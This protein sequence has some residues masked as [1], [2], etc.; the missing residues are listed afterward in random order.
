MF[1]GDLFFGEFSWHLKRTL[2]EFHL[3]IDTH[4][5]DSEVLQ[6]PDRLFPD[7]VGHQGRPTFGQDLNQRRS[8]RDR[9][10]DVDGQLAEAARRH[11]PE[12]KN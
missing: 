1:L 5:V 3:T 7:Q 9:V 2:T 10:D 11:K 8:K 12:H 4:E 6:I